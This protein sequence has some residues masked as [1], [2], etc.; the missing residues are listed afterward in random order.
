MMVSIMARKVMVMVMMRIVTMRPRGMVM[1][2][3]MID[4]LIALRPIAQPRYSTTP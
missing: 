3:R 1:L 4:V 2:M